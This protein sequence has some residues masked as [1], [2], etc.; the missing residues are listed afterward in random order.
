MNARGISL[1]EDDVEKEKKEK[2]KQ[3]KKNSDVVFFT[4]EHTKAKFGQEVQVTTTMGLGGLGSSS[5]EESE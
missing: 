5:D 1:V 4:D 3:E 2:K